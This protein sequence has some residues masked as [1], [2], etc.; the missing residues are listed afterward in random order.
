M[1][2]DERKN[3]PGNGSEEAAAM[4]FVCFKYFPAD[5]FVANNNQRPKDSLVPP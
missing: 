2:R 1:L 5:P 4:L 3:R